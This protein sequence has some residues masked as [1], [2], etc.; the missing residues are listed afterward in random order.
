M[1]F[2]LELSMA[3]CYAMGHAAGL[4]SVQVVKGGVAYKDVDT[5][6]LREEL[7]KDGAV[8]ERRE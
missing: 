8:V 1:A 4:A 3:S 7:R 2:A 6:K 5:R